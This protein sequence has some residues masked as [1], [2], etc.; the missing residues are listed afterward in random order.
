MESNM[1][2]VIQTTADISN[3]DVDRRSKDWT[4]LPT[5]AAGSRFVV[6]PTRDGYKTIQSV[7]HRY[8]WV[9]DRS[10]LGKLIEANSAKVEPVSVRE[11]ARVHGCDY[12]GTEILRALLKLGRIT[13]ADFEAVGKAFEADENF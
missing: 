11:L 12:G 7:E 4:K 8:A 13:A 9:A 10:P 2:Y 6:Q 3:P 5:I 1:T